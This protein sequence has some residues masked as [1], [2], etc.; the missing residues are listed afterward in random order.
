[1]SKISD[2]RIINFIEK[3]NSINK[4]IYHLISS[5]LKKGDNDGEIISK[6]SSYI[7]ENIT[8]EKYGTSYCY[9]YIIA[10][11]LTVT[12]IRPGTERCNN[13][14]KNL[15]WSI[16]RDMIHEYVKFYQD[17]LKPYFIEKKSEI[18]KIIDTELNQE[19]LNS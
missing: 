12:N 3:N 4:E 13:Y 1:M 9:K 5:S 8:F 16:R 2:R 15:M 19:K 18:S 14:C 11:R 6:L 17:V 7:A 10:K